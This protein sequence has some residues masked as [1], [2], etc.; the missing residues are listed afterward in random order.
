MLESAWIALVGLV[1]IVAVDALLAVSAV[2]PFVGQARVHGLVAADA[3][4]TFGGTPCGARWSDFGGLLRERGVWIRAKLYAGSFGI[5]A[6]SEN[7][8]RAPNTL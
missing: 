4:G 8:S 5:T 3:L 1:A 7:R 6:R 2:V